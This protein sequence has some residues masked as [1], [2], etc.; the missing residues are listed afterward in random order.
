M[1]CSIQLYFINRLKDINERNRNLE[2]KLKNTLNYC[3]N[4][5]VLFLIF[6]TLL[7]SY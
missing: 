1:F 4:A 2:F 7:K 3:R 5:Q 6:K